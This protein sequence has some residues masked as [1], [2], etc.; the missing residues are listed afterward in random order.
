[1]ETIQPGQAL[2]ASLQ[3][4][5]LVLLFLVVENQIINVV[6]VVVV[7]VVVCLYC[8]CVSVVVVVVVV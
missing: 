1:M 7:V 3:R 6:V 8:L 2:P 5:R 4:V